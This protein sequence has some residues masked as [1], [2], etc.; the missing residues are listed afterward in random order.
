MEERRLGGVCS[1]RHLVG[2]NTND[3]DRSLSGSDPVRRGRLRRIRVPRTIV[4]VGKLS[5]ISRGNRPEGI[6]RSPW[7]WLLEGGP[8][9]AQP[10]PKNPTRR[11]GTRDLFPRAKR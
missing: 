9:R 2:G 7:I 11:G 6:D 1:G 10:L 5:E 3:G 8:G 4:R